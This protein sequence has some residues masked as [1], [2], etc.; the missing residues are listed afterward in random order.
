MAKIKDNGEGMFSFFCPGCGWAH[1][2]Y[3]NSPHWRKG[4]DSKGWQFN[5]DLNNPTF[6]PSLLNTW[7]KQA[8]PNFI[9]PEGER[10]DK[11][12]WS[13]RCHLFVTNGVINYCGDSTHELSGKQNVPMK[14][15]DAEAH[16]WK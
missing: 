1:V 15:W 3:V 4:G 7:G 10:P 14:D 16:Q 12:G 9:E 8:D 5:G 11:T 13:G 6:T 2:Y